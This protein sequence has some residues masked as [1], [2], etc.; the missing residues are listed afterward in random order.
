MPDRITAGWEKLSEDAFNQA[1]I[2]FAKAIETIDTKLGQD[3]AKNHPELICAFLNAS[4]I[5]YNGTTI[6]A[7]IQQL[8]EDLEYIGDALSNLN[9]DS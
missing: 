2:N 3:Y 6:G 5:E 1:A 8:K 9:L 4:A 7:C